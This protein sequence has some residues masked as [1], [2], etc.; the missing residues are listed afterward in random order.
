[1]SRVKNVLLR[2]MILGCAW[3]ISLSSSLAE[4]ADTAFRKTA[5]EYVNGYLQWR[6]QTG[7]ALGL[8]QFDGN[9]TDFRKASLNQEFNRLKDFDQ[10]LH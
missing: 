9:V 4:S 3:T 10:R 1:M 6:P 5:E 8:H 2:Q 7:T